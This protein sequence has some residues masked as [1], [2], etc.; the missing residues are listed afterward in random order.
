ME[1]PKNI[2]IDSVKVLRP[3]ISA[4]L[5]NAY[6]SSLILK[7][8]SGEELTSDLRAKTLEDVV[9]LFGQVDLDL[10]KMWSPE[11]EAF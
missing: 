8:L 10:L 6:F 11:R 7:I 5:L 9:H 1:L 4:T 3:L 2:I